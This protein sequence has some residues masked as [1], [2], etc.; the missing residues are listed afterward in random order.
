MCLQIDWLETKFMSEKE[1]MLD[2]LRRNGW[3]KQVQVM[4]FHP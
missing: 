4:H 1:R 3:Y 2:W